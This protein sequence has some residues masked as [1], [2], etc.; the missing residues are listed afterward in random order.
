M[1]DV[2]FDEHCQRLWEERERLQDRLLMTI[3]ESAKDVERIKEITYEL[4]TAVWDGQTWTR[5]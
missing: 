4:S 3:E 5:E 1:Y 2:E